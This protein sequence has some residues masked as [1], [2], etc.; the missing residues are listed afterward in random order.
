MDVKEAE[1][2]SSV[3]DDIY[4]ETEEDKLT[5]EKEVEVADVNE[6]DISQMVTVADSAE[7]ITGDKTP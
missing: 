5:G 4:K 3:V 6:L 2:K 1:E 7:D